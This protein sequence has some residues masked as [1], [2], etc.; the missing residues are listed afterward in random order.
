MSA[1]ILA[2]QIQQ[3]GDAI[4][5]TPALRHLINQGH[6]VHLLAQPT[7]VSL[8]QNM[9]GIKTIE[10]L[11]RATYAWQS[12]FNRALRY[13]LQP[14]DITYIF[15]QPNDRN[16]LWAL[17]SRSKKCFLPDRDHI[18]FWVPRRRFIR[19][20]KLSPD[21]HEVEQHL[22]LIGAPPTIASTLNLEYHPTKADILYARALL[23]KHSIPPHTHLHIHLSARW[24][25]KCWPQEHFITFLKMLT[26]DFRIPLF[27]TS[28]PAKDELNYSQKILRHLPPLP[29]ALG[30][31][32]ANQLG[33]LIALCRAFFGMDSMPMHLAAALQ[34][35]G[36]ALFGMT[37]PKNFG[38]WHSPIQILSHPC[39]CRISGHR[40][41]PRTS[42]SDCLKAITPQKALEATLTAYNAPQNHQSS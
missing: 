7:A 36:V 28:G 32:S 5:T 29:S 20:K 15:T 19:I 26:S 14:F 30:N 24:P 8:L 42:Q 16:L 18:P 40:T 31:L 37:N 1:R 6:E 13:I 33:A 38:P 39:H 41:C 10:A 27:L 21:H 17:L 2:I 12:D 9:P 3:P 23:H 22:H 25:S 11:S 4:L 34:I 35:P